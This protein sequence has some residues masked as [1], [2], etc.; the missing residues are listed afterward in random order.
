M[1]DDMWQYYD[2]D[3]NAERACAVCGESYAHHTIWWQQQ[4]CIRC[5]ECGVYV[6]HTCDEEGKHGAEECKFISVA[7]DI[8]K[9]KIKSDR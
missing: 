9:L 2:S 8:R 1:D 5:R 4:L 6:C 3:M 7:S